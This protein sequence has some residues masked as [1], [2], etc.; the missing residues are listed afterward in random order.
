MGDYSARKLD[1]VDLPLPLR[2]LRVGKKYTVVFPLS[3][4]EPLDLRLIVSAD[5]GKGLHRLKR[6]CAKCGC[7]V[8][9]EKE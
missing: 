6:L 1:L 5:W 3:S 2:V 9:L 7:T 8:E 4:D